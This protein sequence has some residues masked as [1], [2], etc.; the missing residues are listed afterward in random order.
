MSNSSASTEDL[1]LVV[2]ATGGVGQLTVNKLLN[3]G[4]KV[5]VL[6]RSA[7][8]AT[9]M[10]SGRVEVVFG[11]IRQPE[12][13]S[14]IMSGV[15]H[16][17]CC[18]GTTAF[19]STRWEFTNDLNPL[20]WVRVFFQDENLISQAK[21]SPNQVDAKGVSNL[22]TAAPSNLKRF[23]FVSSCGV[24]RKDEFPYS[25]LNA[26]GV[27]DG[28]EK[29]EESIISSGIPYTIIR[30]GRLIDGPYTS[31]DLN[32]LTQATTNGKLGVIIGTG[33]TLTGQTSRIDVANVC[34]EC[35][36]NSHCENKAY[37]IVNQGQRP[38]VVDWDALFAEI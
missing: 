3:K 2:G 29:G 37:E 25:L 8:K 13:L 22:V 14:P 12:T 26:F 20:E 21:N 27:L 38:S 15:T 35:L 31:Y 5:R 32:T 17:I 6:T 23:V 11:D 19:P 33:D 18:T 1:V 30:P 24:K 4:F 9:S 10:F 34:V 36:D 7:D 16:I 28:K